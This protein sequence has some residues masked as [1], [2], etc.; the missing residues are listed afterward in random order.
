MANWDSNEGFQTPTT[1]L[2]ALFHEYHD[3]MEQSRSH[4][5]SLNSTGLEGSSPLT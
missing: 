5:H 2:F 3:P 1:G 4:H